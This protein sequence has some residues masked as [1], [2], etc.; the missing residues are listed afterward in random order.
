[1]WDLGDIRE[2]EFLRTN[3][4]DGALKYTAGLFCNIKYQFGNSI[5]YLFL[6]IITGLTPASRQKEIRT[7]VTQITRVIFG[8]YEIHFV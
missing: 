2:V 4:R 1:M 5:P 6:I 7:R 3:W 8:Y